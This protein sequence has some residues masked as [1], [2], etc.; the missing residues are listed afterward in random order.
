MITLLLDYDNAY[1]DDDCCERLSTVGGDA[2]QEIE[3]KVNVEM[4]IVLYRKLHNILY[5]LLY[6]LQPRVVHTLFMPSTAN[7]ERKTQTA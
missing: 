6:S 4:I 5:A 2:E 3:K 7:R 1:D